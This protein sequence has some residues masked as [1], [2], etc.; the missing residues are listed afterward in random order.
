M[1]RTYK[2]DAGGRFASNG[3]SG[4]GPAKVGRAGP[5]GGKTGTRAE[6]R[7]NAKAQQ[8]R[9]QAFRSKATPSAAKAAWKAAAGAARKAARSGPRNGIRPTGGSL[10]AKPARSVIK[11]GPRAGKGRSGGLNTN[12]QIKDAWRAQRREQVGQARW[13]ART[14]A[15]ALADR[16][17]GGLNAEIAGITLRNLGS[18]LGVQQVKRRARRA[19]RLAAAGSKPAARAA[20]LYDQQLAA[21]PPGKPSRKGKSNI[22]PGPRNAN[23]EKKPKRTRKPRKPKA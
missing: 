18:K 23:P 5:R 7:R 10:G 4:R 15:R 9:S 12:R 20:Q 13:M 21:M 22:R 17:S 2:R 3:G 14:Q 16:L 19:A 11:P 1:A 6:Q 8:A